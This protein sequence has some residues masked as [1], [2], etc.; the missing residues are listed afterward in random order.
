MRRDLIP[1]LEK[2]FKNFD[3]EILFD[4]LISKLMYIF[5]IVN[6]FSIILA[7]LKALEA[8]FKMVLRFCPAVYIHA[9]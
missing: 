8:V 2:S 1:S 5:H 3:V 4:V 9:L 7:T 6:E